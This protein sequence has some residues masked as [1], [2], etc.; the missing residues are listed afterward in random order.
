MRRYNLWALLGAMTLIASIFYVASPSSSSTQEPIPVRES[1]KRRMGRGVIEG[2]VLNAE[3]QPVADSDVFAELEE[4]SLT[5]L[6]PAR[7]DQDGNF[8]I[9][10]GEPGT[11]TLSSSN[12]RE[13]YAL[14]LSGFHRDSSI[15]I[16]KVQVGQDE[17]VKGVDINLGWKCSTVRGVIL[18]AATN[19]PINAAS[20]TLRRAD[21]PQIL[22]SVSVAAKKKNGE[23]KVLVPHF[24][25]TMEVS[26]PGYEMWV[27]GAGPGENDVSP[28]VVS[29]GEDR[30]V[31]VALRR[32]E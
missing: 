31:R 6:Q 13:G 20:I 22:Y 1:S 26:S 29:P 9:V 3:G 11:Y 18:D 12:E 5:P 4:R 23:F 15:N 2:R 14:T 19:R 30:E 25:F 17:V 32:Q 8:R 27:A 24:P 28:L 7:S 16:P 21:N 10:V